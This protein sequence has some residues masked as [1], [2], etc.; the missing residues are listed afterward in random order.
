MT[1]YIFKYSHSFWFFAV[2]PLTGQLYHHSCRRK[3]TLFCRFSFRGDFHFLLLFRGWK[4]HSSTFHLNISIFSEKSVCITLAKPQIVLRL[5]LFCSRTSC[6][7]VSISSN[8]LSSS[9]FFIFIYIYYI[10]ILH[11]HFFAFIC[12][13]H[14]SF[15][16]RLTLNFHPP[17][18][19][20]MFSLHTWH[21]CISILL[22]FFPSF[23]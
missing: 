22:F 13:I 15:V 12:C 9:G 11:F 20:V 18:V 4:N 8:I 5:I 10:Q 1:H 14:L 17:C 19:G 21:N 23:W 6:V 3:L 7:F 16:R 2:S